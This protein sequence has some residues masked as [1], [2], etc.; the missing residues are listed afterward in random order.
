[1]RM[2]TTASWSNVRLL[3]GESHFGLRLAF[4][5]FAE[6]GPQRTLLI[7]IGMMYDVLEPVR[8]DKCKLEG[9]GILA[10]TRRSVGL[11]V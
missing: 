10:A 3:D 4:I 9:G 11:S 2:K 5:G 6:D 7:L 1:M 8:H